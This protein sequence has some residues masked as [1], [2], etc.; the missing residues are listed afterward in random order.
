MMSRLAE[1]GSKE[2]ASVVRYSGGQWSREAVAVEGWENKVLVS[3][4]RWLVGRR[5]AGNIKRV[6]THE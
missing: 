6:S 1:K 4:Y 3:E 5:A 2:E